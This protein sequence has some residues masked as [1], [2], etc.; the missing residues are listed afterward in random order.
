MGGEEDEEGLAMKACQCVTGLFV[1]CAGNERVYWPT[2]TKRLTWRYDWDMSGLEH[3]Q[4]HSQKP[5]RS[6]W[7]VWLWWSKENAYASLILNSAA[8][9]NRVWFW[10]CVWF[11][12]LLLRTFS[13]RWVIEPSTF[14]V[15]SDSSFWWIARCRT[16]KRETK[17]FKLPLKSFGS[18]FL[19]SSKKLILVFNKYAK[20][21]LKWP[22]QDLF[23]LYVH[24]EQTYTISN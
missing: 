20:N 18:V 8:L 3:M 10:A 5:P 19:F 24:T 11:Y 4:T 22:F 7:N 21:V 2:V 15:P 6:V 23:I 9:F 13:S 1:R 17:A 12:V 14:S 16:W